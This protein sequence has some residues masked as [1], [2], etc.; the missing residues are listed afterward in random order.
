MRNLWAVKQS[1]YCG[2]SD[3]TMVEDRQDARKLVATI[4][5]NRRYRGFPV[6]TLTRGQSWEVQECEDASMVSDLCGIVRIL[7]PIT[8]T[9]WHCGCDYTPE[10]IPGHAYCGCIDNAEGDSA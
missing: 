1:A 8:A 5:R 6:A 2:M 10:T 7:P 9:C 3:K 4:L